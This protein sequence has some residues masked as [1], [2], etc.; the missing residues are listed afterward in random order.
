MEMPC[1]PCG[2]DARE[3]SFDCVSASR[4]R[5]TYSAQDDNFSAG[6]LVGGGGLAA[7]GVLLVPDVGLLFYSGGL[8]TG[9]VGGEEF[10][11]GLAVLVAGGAGQDGPEVG[12]GQA[13]GDAAACPVT[14][15]ECDLGFHVSVLGSFGK[16]AGG[17]AVILPHSIAGSV[18]KTERV[19]G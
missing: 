5:S 7:Q 12:L 9:H 15:A 10:G 6:R 3:G 11:E 1:E 13:G 19:L 17:L 16:P 14:S 8:R 18:A 4:S 2:G